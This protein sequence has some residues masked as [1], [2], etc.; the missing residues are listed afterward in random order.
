MRKYLQIILNRFTNRQFLFLA[1]ILIGLWAGLTAVVLKLFVHYVTIGI[2]AISETYDWI[3]LVTPVVGICITVLLVR[4]VIREK[5]RPGT[6]H[7]LLA[8]AKKSS[9][10]NKKETYSQALTSAVTVSMGGSVG[11][12]SPIVQTGSAIGSTFASFFPVGYRDR[13]LMLACGAAAGIAAAFNA[14]ITGVL[15]ALEVLLVDIS[16]SSFIPLLI[17]GAVGA[18]C[19]KII[20]KEGILLSFTHVR[21]FDY[22][23]VGFYVLLGLLCGL[24][25]V[26]YVRT[27]LRTQDLLAKYLPG[28]YTRMIIGGLLLGGLIFVFPTLF[29][30]GYSTIKTLAEQDPAK[31]FENS[32]ISKFEDRQLMIILT[33]FVLS[34]V[35][36][37]AVGLTLGSGGN[38]GNFAPSLFVGA[39]LG[40]A[41]SSILVMAG[42][43]RVTVANFTL[44]GMA[45]VLTGVFH[46]PLTGIFLIAEATGGYELM[47]PLM[48]VA[49]LSSGASRF[50]KQQ[51]LDETVLRRNVSNFSFDKDTQL[52]SRLSMTDCIE[53]DFVPVMTNSSLRKLIDIIAHS[54]RNIFPV[55]D[56][57]QQ[58]LGMIALEDIREIMF[59]NS[60]YDETSVNQLMRPPQVVA[61]VDEEMSSVMEKFD[62][63][64]VWNIPVLDNGKYV[65][66]IS[67][68]NIFSK[69]R[70]RLK[71]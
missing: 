68:S 49:A 46:S 45:G 61:T 30:D 34:L 31:L 47:I 29:G 14:P 51:S 38:G 69:Y 60:L 35:K 44:V 64:N 41:F 50:L 53:K 15:F 58:L 16:V 52:L 48:I 24:V 39:C 22:H 65:G 28:T 59:N 36:V 18:L 37:F 71:N 26:Y 63:S 23:N 66:F 10:L 42:F 19:S 9:K 62:K 13:T 27:L 21:E 40:F 3:Y 4:Y 25:S 7:V 33:V 57:N 1:A 55:I 32:F 12:E 20:L 5:L 70:N 17:S 11:L 56:E 6:W 43:D 67:K 2:Q 54:K 8:I